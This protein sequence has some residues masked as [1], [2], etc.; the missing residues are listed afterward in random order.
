MSEVI[1]FRLN[2][3]NPREAQ[4]FEVLNTWIEQGFSARFILTKALLEL[5]HPVSDL[6]MGQD[7]RDLSLVLDQIGQLIE[8]LKEIQPDPLVS[9][10]PD[11]DALAL[12]ESF[13]AAIRHGV[14]PG[15]KPN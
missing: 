15:I 6:K 13:L 4:A 12:S 11:V 14:K 8:A 3:N 10:T 1:S 9:K 2:K 7:G 5:D